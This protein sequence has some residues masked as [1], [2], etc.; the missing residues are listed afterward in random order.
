MALSPDGQTFAS[1]GYDGG[2]VTLWHT[3]TWRAMLTLE[4]PGTVYAMAFSSDGQVLATGCED[5]MIRLWRAAS[6]SE[7]AA[8]IPSSATP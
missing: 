2:T 6:A 5:N 4:H 3:P 8:I 7:A 1:G